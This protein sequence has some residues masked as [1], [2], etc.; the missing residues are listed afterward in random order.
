MQEIHAAGVSSILNIRQ[1][2]ADEM[3]FE[4][5]ADRRS[6]FIGDTEEYEWKMLTATNK[7]FEIRS[8]KIY[9]GTQNKKAWDASRRHVFMR[10]D[11]FSGTHHLTYGNE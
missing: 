9:F 7:P 6:S 4:G 1:K 2:E 10:S 3:P 11:K 5:E 8:L